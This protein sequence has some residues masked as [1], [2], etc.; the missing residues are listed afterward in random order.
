MNISQAL[1]KGSFQK[2]TGDLIASYEAEFNLDGILRYEN[3]LTFENGILI[4]SVESP[5]IDPDFKT[6][7]QRRATK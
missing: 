6:I 7:A 5:I 4:N 3:V 2:I 1:R